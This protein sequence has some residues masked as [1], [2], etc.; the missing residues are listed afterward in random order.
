MRKSK[1]NSMAGGDLRSRL[2]SGFDDACGTLVGNPNLQMLVGVE[3][4]FGFL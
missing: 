2:I 1:R 3:C 4:L